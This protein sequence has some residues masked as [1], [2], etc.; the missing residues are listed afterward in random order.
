MLLSLSL[1]F[2]TGLIFSSLCKKAHLPGLLGMLIS[3]ILLGP[4]ALNWIDG[5]VLSISSEL[6]RMALILIL[7][8]A[9]L[10]LN[11]SD[12]KKAGRPAF[13]ICFVPALFEIAGMVLLAPRLLG[14]SLLDA[15]IMGAVTAAVS[16]AVVV[17]K[18]IRLIEEGYGMEKGIPQM[19]LGG[20]SVDDVFVIVLFTSFTGLAQGESVSALRFLNIPISV[21]LGAAA[22]FLIGA[23]LAEFFRRV[24]MRDTVKLLIL[25]SAAFLLDSAESALHTP[26]TFSALI[27]VMAMGVSLLIR[28][29][30]A[31]RRLS[32]K[33]NALWTAAE[34][35]LFT[36]VGA[37]TDIRCALTFG[38][39][40]VLLIFL[41]LLFRM[42]GTALCL[43]KTRLTPKERLFCMLAYLPKATVQAAIGGVPLAMGLP[44]GA[45]VLTVAVLAIL[46]TAPLGAFLIDNTY[47]RFLTRK[48]GSYA[49]MD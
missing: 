15:A 2:L 11:L 35:L 7:M 40:A 38:G 48:D 6:R 36:L 31:S 42:C 20:A 5:S 9:G 49:Q 3:G 21:F 29:P 18:M 30:I 46:I 4:Y 37:G 25:F 27:A 45:I 14:V 13:L 17:P 10:T 26:I 1:I 44:C 43:I 24:H 39:R 22:G 47:K 34:I 33:L 41:A 16:P 12:L 19:I 8:R 28:L 23:A 32:G